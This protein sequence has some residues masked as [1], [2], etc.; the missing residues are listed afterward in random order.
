M[1]PDAF[2][3]PLVG[4]SLLIPGQDE[5]FRGQCPQP[6]G[7]YVQALGLVF[8]A[9]GN[10]YLYWDNGIPGYEK[11]AAGNPIKE[12]DIIVWRKDFP[13]SNGSGHIDVAAQDGTIANFVA[14]DS[15]WYPPL[16]L[17]K[18][19]HL[20]NNNNYI[21]GYLRRIGDEMVDD[22]GA[23]LILSSSMFLA[24][25]GD[26]PDRQPTLDEVKNLVGRTYNDALTQ[27]MGYQPWKDNYA[28]IK[29]YDQDVKNAGGA[30]QTKLDQIKEIV[31]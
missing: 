2:F 20:G 31:S 12:G 5:R 30:A 11:I 6:V 9:N 15:N 4:Q 23:R 26:T 13:P 16:K 28:K 22:A 3:T 21:A 25:D 10:A 8:P 29:Y 27:V 18:L 7:L 17:A 14:W 24:Q 19:S 1:S